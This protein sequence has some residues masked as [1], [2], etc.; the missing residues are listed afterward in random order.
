MILELDW[1]RERERERIRHL[2]NEDALSP[3]SLHINIDLIFLYSY[4][5]FMASLKLC[6]DNLFS[7]SFCRW[8][9][10]FSRFLWIFFGHIPSAAPGPQSVV[11]ISLERQRKSGHGIG[12]SRSEVKVQCHIYYLTHPSSFKLWCLKF[13]VL[14]NENWK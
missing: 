10:H 14:D 3:V 6:V 8:P 7:F 5:Y 2:S 1:E 12:E 4:M 11:C 13:S 9:W